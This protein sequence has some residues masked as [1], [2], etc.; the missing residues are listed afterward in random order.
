VCPANLDEGGNFGA[1]D[2]PVV[3]LLEQ[4]LEKGANQPVGQLFS[5][6]SIPAGCALV[7]GLH[8]PSLRSGLLNPSTKGQFP[9]MPFSF[10]TPAVLLFPLPDS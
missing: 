8:W 7:Q 9:T 10:W 5:Q 2:V 4:A 1:V 3:K 6:F